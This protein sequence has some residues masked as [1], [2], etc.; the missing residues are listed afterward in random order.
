MTDMLID[1]LARLSARERMLLA[2]ALLLALP[3]GLLF[4]VLL[5][6]H[7]ARGAALEARSDAIAL[8]IWVQDRVAEAGTL[9][10]VAATPDRAPIGT[11]AIEEMLID[12][13]LRDRVS[14]LGADGD[15]V[16]TLRFDDVRFGR[17]AAWLS[18]AHPDWGYDIARLRFE[19]TDTPGNA[20]L[21]LTLIPP[22]G[23]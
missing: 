20:A 5:P 19:A 17:V 8:N 2:A 11:S 15:G 7:D 16:V 18:E 13:G 6:L 10:P 14:Q 1:A 12:Q 4:G 21:A 3:A 23:P 22:E 9:A